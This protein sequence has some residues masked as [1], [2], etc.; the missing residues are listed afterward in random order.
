VFRISGEQHCTACTN[1]ARELTALREARE[2]HGRV[3][4]E[5]VQSASALSSASREVRVILDRDRD[6]IGPHRAPVHA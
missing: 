5:E 4:A 2:R 1:S 3:I 6:A